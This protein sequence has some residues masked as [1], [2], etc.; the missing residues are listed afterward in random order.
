MELSTIGNSEYCL[1]Y[2][3]IHFTVLCVCFVLFQQLAIAITV[4]IA[5]SKG[6]CGER[7]KKQKQISHCRCLDVSQ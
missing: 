5:Y 6:V 3:R 2:H 7:Q 1:L 4:F